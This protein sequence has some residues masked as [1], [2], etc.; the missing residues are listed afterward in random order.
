MKFTAG[1]VFKEIE[2]CGAA[3][4]PL[5]CFLNRQNI[6]LL[7]DLG[8]PAEVF[9]DLQADAVDRLREATQGAINASYFLTWNRIAIP[10]K[11]PQ[12]LLH[13]YDLDI[14][15]QADPFLRRVVE[16]AI[17][18]RLREI[19]YR[20]R[21]PIDQGWTLYGIMDETGYLEE[22]EVYVATQVVDSDGRFQSTVL[23][24]NSVGITRSPALHPGDFQI[25]KAVRPPRDSPLHKLQNCVVFSQHGERDLPSM[26][27]GGDLDG[28]LYNIIT[29]PRLLP[30]TL[31]EAAD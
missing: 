9:L 22:G 27:S 15:F 6:K 5:P 23:E 14:P 30:R 21:I 8:V 28:D 16:I 12:L 7:E 1:Q 2:I 19:K 10:A 29:D 11:T 13:L 20:S 24:Q 17:L 4:K 3:N 25:V 18:S 31:Y 26:L